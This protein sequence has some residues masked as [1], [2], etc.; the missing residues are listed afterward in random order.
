NFNISGGSRN[1]AYRLSAGYDHNLGTRAGSE[2]ERLTLRATNTFRPI[3]GLGIQTVIAYAQANSVNSAGTATS[4]PISPGGGKTSLYP[5]AKLVGNEGNALAIPYLY[6]DNFA[7]TA[8]NGKL[9][10]WKLRPYEEISLAQITSK[11]HHVTA[12]V[13]LSY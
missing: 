5:Y 6:N 2:R 9:L 1:Y 11:T 8:G 3:S 13:N 10:D 7:D 4:F 12:N